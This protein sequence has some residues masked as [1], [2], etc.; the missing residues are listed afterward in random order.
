MTK[1]RCDCKLCFRRVDLHK[2]SGHPMP[3]A[4]PR[5]G[6]E[7]LGPKFHPHGAPMGLTQRPKPT[8]KPK[9]PLRK[10]L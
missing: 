8:K 7:C 5:S 2:K 3:H 6:R 4:D 10:V 9:R 1:V